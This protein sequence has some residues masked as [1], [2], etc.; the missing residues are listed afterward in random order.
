MP[1]MVALLA[2]VLL[3]E[4]FTSKKIFGF[5]L[6]LPGVLAIVWASGSELGSSQNIGHGLFLGAGLAEIV[7]DEA[8]VLIPAG[9]DRWRPI[10]ATHCNTVFSQRLPGPR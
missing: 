8:G 9:D 10:R 7:D 1:L 5:A 6:I 4:E 3:R 2:A